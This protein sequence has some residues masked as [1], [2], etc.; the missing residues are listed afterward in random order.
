L[1][2]NIWLT[3]LVYE[4]ERERIVFFFLGNQ[5]INQTIIIVQISQVKMLTERE[6]ERELF[7]FFRKSAY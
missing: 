3:N 2:Q 6:K 1:Q 4:R 5:H 7:F